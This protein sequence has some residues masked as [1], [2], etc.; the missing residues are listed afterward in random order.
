MFE[1][2]GPTFG[3]LIRQAL[4]S[5]RGGYEMLAPKFDKTPFRTP[6]P[7]VKR[8]VEL[9]GEPV[10]SAIDICSGTG[11][12]L[13]ALRPMTKERLVGVDFSPAM[14]AESKRALGIESPLST[15]EFPRI[16]LVEKDV[17]AIDFDKEFEAATCFGAFGHI[18]RDRESEFLGLVRKALVPGGRFVFVTATKP[19][20][21]NP[22]A[23]LARG[24]NAAM[25]VRNALISPPFIMYYLTFLV[26]DIERK[27]RWAGFDVTLHTKLFEPPFH[28]M[29]AVVARRV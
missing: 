12:G 26:P 5:T 10:R 25:S 18:P 8:T 11:A 27:L 9:L 21:F 15:N 14:I 23:L 28:E 13:L 20:V 17:F 24:F 2:D 3:E 4:Q 19:G 29:V 22:R 16:E 1:K 7:V 6:D